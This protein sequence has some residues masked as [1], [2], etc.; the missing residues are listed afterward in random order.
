MGRTV[1]RSFTL[2]RGSQPSQGV[3][4]LEP[5]ASYGGEPKPITF[6]KI[7]QPELGALL[8][9]EPPVQFPEAATGPPGINWSV[10]GIGVS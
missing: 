2:G 3:L 4:S 10:S 6:R 7:S 1:S 9:L 5:D 8:L